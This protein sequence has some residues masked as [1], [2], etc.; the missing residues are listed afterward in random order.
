MALQSLHNGRD[1][2]QIELSSSVQAVE[3]I[4]DGILRKGRSIIVIAILSTVLFVN[5]VSN[6]LLTVG[7]PR[8][9]ADLKLSE[10][11]LFW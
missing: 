3:I 4:A 7:I 11:L 9:A 2:L 5:S 8:M 1:Q 10:D 6:G